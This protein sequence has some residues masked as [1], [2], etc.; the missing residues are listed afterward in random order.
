MDAVISHCATYHACYCA[1]PTA[2][3]RTQQLQHAETYLREASALKDS[4]Y[5]AQHAQCQTPRV[6]V[7]LPGYGL[8]GS[9][10][11][12]VQRLL[13]VWQPL[14]LMDGKD[15]KLAVVAEPAYERFGANRGDA[16]AFLWSAFDDTLPC[17]G[18]YG[19][20]WEEMARQCSDA[21]VLSQQNNYTARPV[22]AASHFER[23]WGALLFSAAVLHAWWRPTAALRA[24]LERGVQEIFG[25]S[26]SRRNSRSHGPSHRSSD[27]SARGSSSGSSSGSSG[28]SSENCLALHIRRGDAC[29][30]S[31]RRCP[32]LEAYL[33]VARKLAARY[34]LTTLFVASDDANVIAQL[35]ASAASTDAGG[36]APREEPWRRVV[37]Q[38]YDRSPFNASAHVQRSTRFW[39]EQRL[40]WSKPGQRPLGTRPVYEFLLD[41]EAGSQCSALVGT[42]DSHGSRLMLLR[43][44]A[45][46]GATPPFY[47]LVAPVCPLT[48][49][50][51][52]VAKECNGHTLASSVV[53]GAEASDA[54]AFAACQGPQPLQSSDAS[55]RTASSSAGGTR[56]ARARDRA[57]A[58]HRSV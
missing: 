37:W 56:G 52:A 16:G 41:V 22:F 21:T 38:R 1:T 32:Y 42:M 58:G 51:H 39:V 6:R 44:A 26:G 13:P 23:R 19:C 35:G 10:L 49:L 7:L 25:S 17:T 14:L 5:A 43:M 9:I 34:G 24:Q 18:W 33:N 45:R 3:Q 46:L 57:A 4:V 20:Y 12:H 40:R 55:G 48:A 50:P 2:L 54:V 29:A 11:D 31:W 47:S 36:G 27:G 28:S 8:G 53:P 30:T 15:A